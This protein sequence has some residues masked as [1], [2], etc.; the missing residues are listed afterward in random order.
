MSGRARRGRVIVL[1]ALNVDVVTRV[2]R[3]PR[4]GETAL[5]TAPTVRYAGG[6]GGNQAVA[7]AAAGARTVLVGAVGDD[8]SGRR[9]AARLA[10]RGIETRLHVAPG[11]PTGTAYIT[12]DDDGENVIVVDAGANAA[13]APNADLAELVEP[14]DVLL[15]QLE[16]P[17]GAVESAVRAAAD[18]G[19][20]IVLNAAPFHTLA[21]DVVALAD[22]LVVNEHEA[23]LLADAGLMPGSLLVTFGGAGAQWDDVRVDAIQVPSVV[24][25]VGAGDAFCGALAAALAAGGPDRSAALWAAAVAGAEAVQR[26]GAQ[27]DPVL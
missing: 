25:S 16:I 15:A 1:G 13:V 21:P 8:D 23:A 27:P 18:R 4:P 2:E 3:L 24:D 11:L 17:I 9:Y 14:G 20:R 19:A 12:V 10:D 6:K 5:A 7:A 22:P 26:H